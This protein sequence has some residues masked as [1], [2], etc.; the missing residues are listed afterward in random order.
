MKI[1]YVTDIG[2]TVFWKAGEDR[3]SPI[4]AYRIFMQTAGEG[5][6]SPYGNVQY[7][8]GDLLKVDDGYSLRIGDVRKGDGQ[9]K[10]NALRA[11]TNYSFQ[12]AAVNGRGVG[13]M[14]APTTIT[15]TRIAGSARPASLALDPVFV[16]AV[17]AKVENLV[18][19]NIQATSIDLS[20]DTP[21]D[22]GAEI[23]GYRVLSIHCPSISLP[24][25]LIPAVSQCKQGQLVVFLS[26]VL[27]RIAMLHS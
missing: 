20:W 3:G 19:S 24:L 5:P 23:T 26:I 2:L 4:V 12:V 21:Y 17:P 11:A 1:G 15:Q 10:E 13:E 27:T 22:S 7:G 18:V 8:T 6:F 14:C 9:P 25:A 16:M